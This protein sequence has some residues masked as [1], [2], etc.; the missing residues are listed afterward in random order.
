VTGQVTFVDFSGEWQPDTEATVEL[1]GSGGDGYFQQQPTDT[2]GSYRF[3]DVPAGQSLWLLARSPRGTSNP[4]E[5]FLA[6]GETAEV[7]LRTY[8]GSPVVSVFPAGGH[9]LLDG[10]PVAGAQVWPLDRQTLAVSDE[11]GYFSFYY[12]PD[13]PVVALFED[14]WLVTRLVPREIIDIELRP[15]QNH[16]TPPAGPPV[17]PVPV[18]AGEVEVTLAIPPEILL[19]PTMPVLEPASPEATRPVIEIAPTRTGL[20]VRPTLPGVALAPTPSPA[21]P[22]GCGQQAASADYGPL[23]PGSVVVLGP[24]QSVKGTDSWQAEMDKYVDQKAT[25]TE[26]AGVDKVGCPGVRVDL[27]KGQNFWRIRALTLVEP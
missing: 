23:K 26:L 7:E 8:T 19:E 3:E 11:S 2:E 16:P 17:T 25:V 4:I 10:E 6:S 14:H 20:Q 18:T 12:V 21:I 13:T 5:H 15:G 27:D 9:I 1:V 24:H 22:T